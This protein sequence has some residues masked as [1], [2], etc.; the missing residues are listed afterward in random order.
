MTRPPLS[1]PAADLPYPP[2]PPQDGQS[3]P[4]GGDGRRDTNAAAVLLTVLDHGP[5]ARTGIAR[6]SGLSPAAVS[7]QYLDLARLGL[8]R[9][10]PESAVGGAV[11][12]PQVPV[13]I[14]TSGPL[15]AGVH[16]GVP[17][18]TLSLVD[19]RGRTVA[20]ETVPPSGV[21]GGDVPAALLDRLPEFI[22]GRSAGRPVLGVGAIT[23][24]W[25]DP[26]RGVV[27]RHVPLGWRD[28]PLRARL[29]HACGLPVRV[30]NH[31]RAIA[32]S[33]ILFGRARARRSVVHLFVGS[34][35]DAALGIAGVVH[36]GP[37]SAA[38]DVAHL[39]VDDTDARCPCGRTGCLQAAASD[40]ALVGRAVAEGVLD[41]PDV[42]RLVEL[43]AA[44]DRRADRL[45][46]HRVR[47]VAQ[48]AAL[49]MD[50]VNPDLVLVTEASTLLHADYLAVLRE[51]LLARSRIC[52]DPERV[53]VSHAGPDALT[54]AAGTAVLAPLYRSPLHVTALSR[55][56]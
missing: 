50:V 28:V 24:G 45:L 4:R 23:G 18:A 39:P 22:A 21:G 47:L 19:L 52:D 30:D 42:F 51:E 3:G 26:G 37:R 49:L 7:R 55:T 10:R 35:V 14:D 8:V 44:G 9:E 31:A 53:A 54:V 29:E 56:P 46:R 5:I 16:L 15:A 6:L 25:V 38:G 34:V 17:Y 43:A 12:R 36:Q 32:Q 11:G 48:A 33:E 2:E 20:R 41:R 27:V 13:D 1:A 40:E